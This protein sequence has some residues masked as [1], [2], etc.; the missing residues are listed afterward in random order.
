M[1]VD[2]K[3][4]ATTA[5]AGGELAMTLD[6]RDGHARVLHLRGVLTCDTAVEAR[7]AVVEQLALVPAV[8]VLD[9]SGLTFVD[10]CG[11]ENLWRMAERAERAEIDMRLVA[12][13]PAWMHLSTV[14]ELPLEPVYATVEEALRRS[15][16]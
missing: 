13:G 8:L 4:T 11:A 5:R 16:R 14:G 1:H 2:D 12:S 10:R 9:L 6:R 15:D 3:R 7:D